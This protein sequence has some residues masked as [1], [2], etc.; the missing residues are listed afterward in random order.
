MRRTRGFPAPWTGTI[1]WVEWG[2]GECWEIIDMSIDVGGPLSN[3]DKLE[4]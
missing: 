4:T 3:R 2:W 1:L